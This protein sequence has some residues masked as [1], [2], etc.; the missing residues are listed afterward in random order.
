[1][2]QRSAKKMLNFPRDVF[3]IPLCCLLIA[4]AICLLAVLPL[5]TPVQANPGA[6]ISLSPEEGCVGDK[7]TVNGEGF[8]SEEEVYVYYDG[9]LQAT[10]EVE[11]GK[12]CP[13]GFFTVSFTVPEARK[14]A[15]LLVT[16]APN[17]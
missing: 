7:L 15:E 5:A 8:H 11:W 4:V 13:H 17:P 9:V 1:M 16:Q 10:C 2:I 3:S 14:V 12:Q 6:S